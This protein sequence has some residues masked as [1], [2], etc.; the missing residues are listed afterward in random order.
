MRSAGGRRARRPT[1]LTGL[2]ARPLCQGAC[3][4]TPLS[5]T[6]AARGWMG[7]RAV[8]CPARNELRGF[9]S[10][11]RTTP[12]ELTDGRCTAGIIAAGHKRGQTRAWPPSHLCC[13]PLP[14]HT[15]IVW[16]P[17]TQGDRS[18]GHRWRA[19][20]SSAQVSPL[21]KTTQGNEREQ[22]NTHK[23]SCT[24]SF[25]RQRVNRQGTRRP[26]GN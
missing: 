1:R 26:C 17:T 24:A 2:T 6:V 16:P 3:I 20:A 21:Q 4:C 14:L 12:A 18:G 9:L 25:L 7:G 23:M 15:R 13:T 19:T 11:G 8:G 22:K 5:S 10:R